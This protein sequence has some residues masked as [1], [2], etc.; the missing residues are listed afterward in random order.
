MNWIQ[1]FIMKAN[2]YGGWRLVLWVVFCVVGIPS[3]VAGWVL[4]MGFLSSLH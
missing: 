2:R 1:T 4:L 3:I